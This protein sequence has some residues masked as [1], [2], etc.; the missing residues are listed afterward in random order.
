[1]RAL[2]VALLLLAA[3]ETYYAEY[4]MLRSDI[5]LDSESV[6]ESGGFELGSGGNDVPVMVAGSGGSGNQLL[7]LPAEGGGSRSAGGGSGSGAQPF[8]N[9]INFINN[10]Y[11]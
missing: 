10:D 9:V 7:G 3:A 11:Q 2:L 8:I 4:L 5:E 6:G 1:M